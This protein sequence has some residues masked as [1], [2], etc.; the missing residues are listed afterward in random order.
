MPIIVGRNPISLSIQRNLDK[1]NSAVEQSSTRLASGLRINRASDDAAGLSV[2]TSL[3]TSQRVYTQAIRNVQDAVSA[4]SITEGAAHE[5][6]SILTRVAELAEQA[7]NGSYST[8]QRTALDN[9][10]QQLR[11]EYQRITQ[12]TKFNGIALMDGTQSTMAVQAGFNDAGNGTIQIALPSFV[13]Y[14][15][16]V[17]TGD[18]TFTNIYTSGSLLTSGR[19]VA[20]ADFNGDGNDDMVVLNEIT[21]KANVFLGN[22]NGTYK[23]P[24]SYGVGYAT[25]YANVEAADLNNDG[26]ADFVV[27]EPALGDC[28]SVFM[29]NAD[30]TFKLAVSYKAGDEALG[31][32]M[33]DLDRD[34]DQDIV[35]WDRLDS[36]MSVFLNNGNGTF[37]ARSSYVVP[38]SN[39]NF[40]YGDS[41]DIN[42]DTFVDLVA[43]NSSGDLIAVYLGNSNGTFNA[44]V[45]YVAQDPMRIVLGDFNEDGIYDV[46][47][48][49]SSGPINILIGNSDG[50]LKA[51]TQYDAGVSSTETIR[52]GDFNGDG[53]L[54]LVTASATPDTLNI[55]LG[56]GNG[57]FKAATT[58]TTGND[59]RFLRTG[60]FNRDGVTDIFA[61]PEASPGGIYVYMGNS[62]TTSQTTTVLGSF[63]LLTQ[64]SA[65]SALDSVRA[66][67]D[68]ITANIGKLGAQQARL[69]VTSKTLAQS[70]DG[71]Q[72][73]ASRIM[74]ADIATEVATLT[75]AKIRQDV[76][77]NL[78]AQANQLP[79]LTLQLLKG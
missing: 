40:S 43:S 19:S 1:A 18:G 71:F 23:A 32:H 44:P 20:L 16:S 4:L 33:A 6:S 65:R 29:S 63:S 22:G 79:A 36:R 9:E 39:L 73:A 14:S 50:T 69:A 47:T 34:G 28:I 3:Q 60:D 41:A 61:A 31:M 27:S 49:N 30:G 2:A 53:F 74:D 78:L 76:A 77:S 37:L 62:Q 68:I 38:G 75:S 58:I 5:L 67:L 13:D 7:A 17:T 46:A 42:G 35:T 66:S 51:A 45:S 25:L 11:L 59:V 8:A 72:G 12:T 48:S 54:D 24:V 52:T 56:N 70:R 26:H 21:T 64:S 15:S 10:A 57:S 55:I